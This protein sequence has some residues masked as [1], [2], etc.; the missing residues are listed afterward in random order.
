MIYDKLSQ[1]LIDIRTVVLSKGQSFGAIPRNGSCAQVQLCI[2]AINKI[3]HT[4]CCGRCTLLSKDRANIIRRPLSSQH[5]ATPALGR[6]AATATSLAQL[7]VAAASCHSNLDAMT[8]IGHIDRTGQNVIMNLLGGIDEGILHVE[9]G[10]GTGF[11]KDQT[12]L[13][14]ERPSLLGG[15]RTA[16]LQIIF[17]ADQHDNHVAL[18]V[19]PSL[20]EPPRQVLEGVPPCYVVDEEGT[21]GP[22]V[23]RSSD[24]AERLLPRG[25]PNLQLHLLVVDGYHPSSELNADGQVVD[26]LES[27][28]GELQEKAGLA[29]TSITND[30]I[31]E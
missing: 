16:V 24:G 20:L 18:A 9:G 15:H 29:D 10:L 27:L 1:F 5:L 13:L 28:V 7:D 3:V 17:V 2:R 19:L 21:G 26:R 31:F 12:I 14:R 6:T 25:I 30:D 22:S 8:L 11:Q 23:V 4:G